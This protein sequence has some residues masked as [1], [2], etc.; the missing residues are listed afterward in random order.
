MDTLPELA[1]QVE[2]G[3]YDV[4]K[5]AW[6]AFSLSPACLPLFHIALQAVV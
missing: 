6:T 5:A 2:F 3:G 4:L 1:K